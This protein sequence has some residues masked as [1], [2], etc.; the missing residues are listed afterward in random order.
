MVYY[1]TI[2]QIPNFANTAA[3]PPGGGATVTGTIDP[4]RIQGAYNGSFMIQQRVGF[5]T[6]LEAAWV[7]NMGLHLST[8]SATSGYGV[9][10]I[11]AVAPYADYNPA[12]VNPNVGYIPAN[13]SGKNLNQNY[14][15]PIQ[16]YG[17]IVEE[18]FDGHSVF[19]SLQ[20][21]IRRNM[22]KHLSYGLAY[23]LGKSMS[24]AT[25]S[26]Y[27]ADKFRNYGPAYQ[28]APSVLAINYVYEVPNLGQKLNF[29][30]LGVVTDHW[31]ISGIT[32]WHSDIMT[33][34]PGLSFSGTTSSNPQMDWTGGYEGAR[35]MVVGN[36]ELPQSQVSFVGA[37][38]LVQ[39]AGANVNGSPGNQIINALA[40]VDPYPCS[41]TPGATPQKGI[42]ESMEC[43]GNAGTG[44]IMKLPLTRMDN[45]DMTLSKNFP[46]KSEKRVLMFRAEMYN[47]PNHTQFSSAGVTPQYNWPNWQNG[48][49]VQTSS[50]L[51]R[52]SG[53]QTPRQM[54]MS[55]RFQF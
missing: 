44:S 53:T 54:S 11:N 6:V 48:I 34:I 3:I 38:P 23:T 4:Q 28:G 18:N 41:Y 15:R 5:A 55:L 25:T 2:D 14:Y 52:F 20:V 36:P 43:Y 24:A 9:H 1:T 12:N 45:W 33:S 10:Q 26:P 8:S 22:T 46:L 51:G 50:S 16:G 27:F 30:P 39:A 21:T 7:F 49:L 31:T 29:K 13:A 35:V 17:T 37:T 42:G 47:L 32:Q 40:F 19:N